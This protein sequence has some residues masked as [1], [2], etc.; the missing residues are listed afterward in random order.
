MTVRGP[1]F[2]LN[3]R[4]STAHGTD[5]VDSP[6]WGFDIRARCLTAVITLIEATPELPHGR[7]SKT[8]SRWSLPMVLQAVFG[9]PGLRSLR[10][11]GRIGG[12][13]GGGAL[14][15]KPLAALLVGGLA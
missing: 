9:A 7:W 12:R 15:G 14:A 2:M 13:I 6:R 4:G 10:P 5:A 1:A 8:L 11:P 3:R